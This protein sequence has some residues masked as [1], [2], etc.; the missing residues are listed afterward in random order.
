MTESNGAQKIYNRGVDG[1]VRRSTQGAEDG[2]INP[3]SE[4]RFLVIA[5][6][7]QDYRVRPPQM[8]WGV[9]RCRLGTGLGG[10]T[11]RLRRRDGGFH[12]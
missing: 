10:C 7:L 4:N 9:V 11:R 1:S 12:A 5:K 8:Q 3:S 2:K 6:W